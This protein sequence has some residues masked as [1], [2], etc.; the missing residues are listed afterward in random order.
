MNAGGSAPIIQPL[1]DL[2][3]KVDADLTML[4]GDVREV[5]GRMVRRLRNEFS[6][7]LTQAAVLGYLDREGSRSIGELAARERVRPQSMSQTLAELETMGLISRAPDAADGRRTMISLTA[8]G[9]A[10]LLEERA[11]RDGWLAQAI[12]DL[13]DEERRLLGDAVAILRRI[14]DQV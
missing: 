7:P 1:P 4:A 12:S 8:A 14:A 10:K 3:E 11:R 13:S 9:T 5:V 6:L 2:T